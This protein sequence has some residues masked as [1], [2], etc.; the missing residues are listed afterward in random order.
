V[1]DER[2]VDIDP[3]ALVEAFDRVLLAGPYICVGTAGDRRIDELLR[4]LE[5]AQA[6]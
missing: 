3:G 1:S 5:L 4:R 6:S 2:A